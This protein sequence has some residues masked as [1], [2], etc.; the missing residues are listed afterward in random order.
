MRIEAFGHTHIGRSRGWN[1]DNY[2][3]LDLSGRG[4]F[5]W[6][7][8]QLL[9]V[10]DGIGGHAGGGLASSL[11]IE[12]LQES[13]LSHLINGGAPADF[14]EI[15][16]DANNIANAKIFGAASENEDCKGMGTTLAAA[17]VA[18]DR[19]AVSNVGDSR[20]YLVRNNALHQVSQ[21]HSWSAEQLR[22]NVLSEQEIRN[23]PFKNMITRSLGFD[24]K[25][26]IDTFET[27]LLEDDYL[28]L[29]TDGLHGEV[30]EPLILKIIRR[31]K[32]PEKICRKLIE[33][34]NLHGGRDNITTVVAYLKNDDPQR[35]SIS[36]SICV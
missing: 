8:L 26:A 17:L 16:R 20:V 36:P 7:P 34:A 23:S 32:T 19:A 6:H 9:A 27:V 33:K 28:L 2:L 18:G 21:D 1:E 15:L 5:P 29:C 31:K 30:D 24:S 11:A 10:A 14:Q 12:I 13:V 22:L 35:L 25:I 4:V 3:C